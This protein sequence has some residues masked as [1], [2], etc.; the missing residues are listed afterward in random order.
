MNSGAAAVV[1][2]ETAAGYGAGEDVATVFDVGGSG[3]RGVDVRVWKGAE[4][5]DAD[6]DVFVGREDRSRRYAAW[7]GMF[8]VLLILGREDTSGLT[9]CRLEIGLKVHIEC[10]VGALTESLF[11]AHFIV[12]SSPGVVDMASDSLQPI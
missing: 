3:A 11:H 12:V 2:L 7:V 6:R 4:A 9:G 1:L 8:L 10:S 5:E